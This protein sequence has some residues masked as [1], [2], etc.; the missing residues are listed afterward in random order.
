MGWD[1]ALLNQRCFGSLGSGVLE[2]RAVGGSAGWKTR[3]AEARAAAGPL[4]V[5]QTGSS[6][7][8][9]GLAAVDGFGFRFIKPKVF[10][11]A[12]ERSLGGRALGALQVGKPAV[13]K[14]AAAGPRGFDKL[15]VRRHGRDW[16][17]L[18]GWDSALLNQR[19]FRPPG[20]GVWGAGPWG[21]CRLESP[22]YE[23]GAGLICSILSTRS[24]DASVTVWGAV[25]GGAGLAGPSLGMP[26]RHPIPR[27]PP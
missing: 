27:P 5:R 25:L 26:Q 22:Q 3:S 18:M 19:C 11:A 7:P 10:Q 8:R 23:W 17:L 2:G 20:S 4:R 21:L 13:R 24:D 1:S 16:R 14:R 9:E 15:E 12:G 6:S